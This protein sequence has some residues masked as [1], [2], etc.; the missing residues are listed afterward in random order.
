MFTTAEP[1]I[2]YNSALP[3]VRPCVRYH[4]ITRPLAERLRGDQLS[5]ERS[6]RDTDAR[7][8]EDDHAEIRSAT[9][10]NEFPRS[11]DRARTYD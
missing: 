2:F 1:I 4:A 5:S 11:P 6:S 3:S 8:S 10:G 9:A 7:R